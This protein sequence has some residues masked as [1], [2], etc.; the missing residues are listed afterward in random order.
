MSVIIETERL[1]LREISQDDFPAICAIL[2]NERV[3]YA[4]EHTFTH[5]EVKEWITENIMRYS[6]DGFSYWAVIERTAHVL[7]GVAGIIME[8]VDE[9]EHVGIGY[10]FNDAYWHRGFAFEAAAACVRYAFEVLN[11]IEITAQIRP[12][13][14]SSIHVAEKLGM[15][16]VR[17]FVRKYRGK[18]FPH[19]LY[20][21]CNSTKILS[22]IIPM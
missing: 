10:I 12:T 14:T 8:K 13:N 2:R 21:L 15:K 17:P 18:D 5:D 1:S 3:M 11:I 22:K 20:S 7:I 4:W 16:A 6:R 9:E 19:I